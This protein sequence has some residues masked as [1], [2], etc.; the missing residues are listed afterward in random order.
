MAFDERLGDRARTALEFRDELSERRMF[1]GLAFMIAG[2]M[3]C[4]VIGDELVVRMAPVDVEQALGEPGTRVFDFTGRPSRGMV[5]VTPERLEDDV[6][7]AHW[8]EAGADF[9]ASLPPK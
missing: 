9:A 3:A 7:L 4:G 8:V 6:E 2:N 1:G 5:V